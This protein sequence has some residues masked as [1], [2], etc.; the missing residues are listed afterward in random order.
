MH[1]PP[2]WHGFGW[3]GSVG[4]WFSHLDPENPWEHWHINELPRDMHLPPFWH[5]FGSHGFG[6][7]SLLSQRW[8]VKPGGQRHV[9]PP[10]IPYAPPPWFM[11]TPPFWQGFGWHGSVCIWFSQRCPENPC[12]HWQ[13]NVLPCGKHWP[14]L[15]GFG[16]HGFEFSH[17]WPEKPGGHWHM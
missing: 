10:P 14:T 8:P 17:L 12:G 2:F 11:Q 1:M 15:Q 16:M 3:H 4:I 7:C 13:I 6:G 5:G 9:M